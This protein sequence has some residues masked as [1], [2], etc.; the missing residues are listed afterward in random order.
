M[1][2]QYV[3]VLTVAVFLLLLLPLLLWIFCDIQHMSTFVFDMGWNWVMVFAE[4]LNK[5]NVC[6]QKYSLKFL[7]R[8][9]RKIVALVMF[10]RTS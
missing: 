7:I 2:L 1:K 4:K 10:L 5:I 9:L 8:P 3:V 6:L